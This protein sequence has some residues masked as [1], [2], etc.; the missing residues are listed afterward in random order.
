MDNYANAKDCTT[1]VL[2]IQSK[3]LNVNHPEYLESKKTM[4]RIEHY[5][6]NGVEK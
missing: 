3:E 1:E 5:L 6:K 4:A 2:A